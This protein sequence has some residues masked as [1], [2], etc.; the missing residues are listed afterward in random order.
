MNVCVHCALFMKHEQ[1]EFICKLFVKQLFYKQFTQKIIA[2]SLLQYTIAIKYVRKF[3][4]MDLILCKIFVKLLLIFLSNIETISELNSSVYKG[5]VL[6]TI[7]IKYVRHISFIIHER[8]HFCF[9]LQTA[10]TKKH[11]PQV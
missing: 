3:A 2:P 11:S 4:L 5:V 1:N 8:M 9:V 10:Y 7:R 6:Q